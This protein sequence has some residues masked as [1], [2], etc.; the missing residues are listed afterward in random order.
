[1]GEHDNQVA[2]EGGKKGGK[3]IPIQ[4]EAVAAG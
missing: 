3:K 1:M 2:R 4:T